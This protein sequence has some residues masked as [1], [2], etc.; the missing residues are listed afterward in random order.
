MRAV[1]DDEAESVTVFENQDS[2]LLGALAR[3]NALVVRAPYARDL[4]GR[5]QVQY[6]PL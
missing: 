2:S 5:A 4:K 3:A 1:V 6:I